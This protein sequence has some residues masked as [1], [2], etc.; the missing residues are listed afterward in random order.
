MWKDFTDSEHILKRGTKVLIK[1]SLKVGKVS[2]CVTVSVNDKFS[3]MC[4]NIKIFKKGVGIYII[5][6]CQAFKN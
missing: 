4:Y 3:H 1:S 2:S 5:P 6:K